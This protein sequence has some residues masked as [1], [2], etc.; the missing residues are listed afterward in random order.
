MNLPISSNSSSQSVQ[1]TTK[2]NLTTNPI[3]SSPLFGLIYAD[4]DSTTTNSSTSNTP[5]PTFIG[6]NNSEKIELANLQ[7]WEK[8][9]K[10]Q[11]EMVVTRP[12]RF[13]FN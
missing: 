12:G 9:S 4:P 7:L 8:F 11:N 6:N 1:Q 13:V 2:T 10:V 3:Q 5:I